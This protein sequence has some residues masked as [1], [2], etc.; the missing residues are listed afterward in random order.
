MP[1]GGQGFTLGRKGAF[2][3]FA[4][5]EMISIAKED[6][7]SESATEKGFP[8]LK[9]RGIFYHIEMIDSIEKA[10]CFLLRGNKWLFI[11]FSKLGENP[12]Y[13]CSHKFHKRDIVCLL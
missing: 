6:Q 4:Q 11:I 8:I 7:P 13:F 12:V 1:I 5:F 2:S 9:R 10:G 3:A